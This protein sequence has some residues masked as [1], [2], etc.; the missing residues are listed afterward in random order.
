M[1]KQAKGF[2]LIELMIVIAIVGILASVSIPQYRDYVI[3]AKIT[4]G[5]QIMQTY[6]TLIAEHVMINGSFPPSAIEVLPGP[7]AD[8]ITDRH[9]IDTKHF[10][11][12]Y[13]K[14]NTS[15]SGITQAEL[16]IHLKETP[17][18]VNKDWVYLIGRLNGDGSVNW[19]CGNDTRSDDSV[20]LKYLPSSCSFN[21]NR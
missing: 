2:T 16:A 1:P 3:R 6:K 9:S 18:T 20:E 13:Y 10:D 15:V 8:N 7:F 14:I 4:E 11:V 5:F 12:L 19:G 21:S 17:E